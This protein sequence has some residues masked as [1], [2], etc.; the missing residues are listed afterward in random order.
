MGSGEESTPAK[1]PT[2]N[3][4]AQVL[5]LFS[6][7]LS[8]P[9]KLTPNFLVIVCRKH[10]QRLHTMIGR[11][12][13]RYLDLLLVINLFFV[14]SLTILLADHFAPSIGILWCC[15]HSTSL[16][17]FQCCIS[18]SSPIHVGRPGDCYVVMTCM[19]NKCM[20][21]LRLRSLYLLFVDALFQH[22][23]SPYGTPL[24]YPALY[25]HGVYPHPT[26]PSVITISSLFT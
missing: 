3:A 16:F 4:S 13:C 5:L 12:I 10:L 14:V 24:P 26:V 20:V 1:P 2:A 9:P 6:L 17:H 11:L 8:P 7:S 19:L 18:N 25:P 22:L 15:S 23:M 21:P